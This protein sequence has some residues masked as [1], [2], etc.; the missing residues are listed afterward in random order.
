MQPTKRFWLVGLPG[1]GKSTR[2][3]AF[4][5]CFMHIFSIEVPILDFGC[6][7]EE[8]EQ[9]WKSTTPFQRQMQLLDR[10]ETFI[11]DLKST[12]YIAP[13][14]P[15]N[16]VIYTEWL[17]YKNLITEE[18]HKQIRSKASRLAKK[19]GNEVILQH[20]DIPLPVIME[21]LRKRGN[22]G[23]SIYTADDLKTMNF[24]QQSFIDTF[25]LIDGES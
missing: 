19:I 13:L 5:K 17:I 6:E 12:D 23:D 14:N 16:V 20:L 1:S 25:G 9:L 7:N 2:A 8:D 4:Q 15:A 11:Q 24:M 22:F 3:L 10:I 18:E 21:R